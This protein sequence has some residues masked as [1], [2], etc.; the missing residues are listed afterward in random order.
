M[1]GTVIAWHTP[2]AKYSGL[3]NSLRRQLDAVGQQHRIY[4]FAVPP[5]IG[6]QEII[7]DIKPKLWQRALADCGGPILMLDVDCNVNAPL[8]KLWDTMKGADIGLALH[9]KARTP[10][11]GPWFIA[12]TRALYI[13]DTD[14][15]RDFLMSWSLLTG[16]D[17]NEED[18]LLRLLGS[19]NFSATLKRI[20]NEFCAWESDRAPAGAI[21]T[22]DSA[23]REDHPAWKRAEISARKVYRAIVPKRAA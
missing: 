8:D 22:H 3:A 18:A 13:A 16:P 20:P 14:A 11:K 23:H 5:G 6:W 10:R 12:S 15:A 4:E 1:T 9:H 7:S 21:I 2:D 17:D 19:T